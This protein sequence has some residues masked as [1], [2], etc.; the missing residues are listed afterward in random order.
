VERWLKTGLVDLA[1]C[2]MPQPD[3]DFASRVLFDDEL[4][5]VSSSRRAPAALGAD[6]VYVDHGDEFRRQHAA[7]FPGESTSAITIASSEWAVE[8]LLRNGGSG[9]LSRRHVGEHL[10]GGRLHAVGGVPSFRRRVYLVEAT[11]TVS[12][13]GWYEAAIAAIGSSRTGGRAAAARRK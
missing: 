13:W 8:H 9:Y 3:E 1:F 2:Y 10:R 5:L 11:H 12:R 4:I 7:A 6:Y